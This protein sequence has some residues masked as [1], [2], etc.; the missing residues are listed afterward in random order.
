MREIYPT[1]KLSL[2]VG[3]GAKG[4][5]VEWTAERWSRIN[6]VISISFSSFEGDYA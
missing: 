2:K 3:R 6:P 5:G 4:R 1:G